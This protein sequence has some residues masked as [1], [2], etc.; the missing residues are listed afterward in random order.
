MLR[1]QNLVQDHCSFLHIREN[2]VDIHP[3][4]RQAV[5]KILEILY[6]N[7]AS[8]KYH[9]HVIATPLP[10]LSMLLAIQDHAQTFEWR[11]GKGEGGGGLSYLTNV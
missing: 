4:I 8:M 7:W 2:G 6:L 9:D 10:L 11:G 3:S 1:F 5:A